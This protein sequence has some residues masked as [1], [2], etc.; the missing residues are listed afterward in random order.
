MRL[1]TFI[2]CLAVIGVVGCKEEDPAL[3]PLP[4]R[5]MAE[6]DVLSQATRVFRPG[7]A[8]CSQFHISFTN[9]IWE[10]SCE[11]NHVAKALTIQ[12]ADGKMEIIKP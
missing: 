7:P 5:R 2:A 3:K 1:L 9:G 8:G 4:G 12:D 6:V 10:V 11:S